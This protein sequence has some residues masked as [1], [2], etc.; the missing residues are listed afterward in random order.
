VKYWQTSV[1]I[2]AALLLVNCEKEPPSLPGDP[3][4]PPK[5]VAFDKVSSRKALEEERT[6]LEL[7]RVE[8]EK[9]KKSNLIQES[10]YRRRAK[11]YEQRITNNKAAFERLKLGN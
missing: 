5:I 10:E 11:V 9:A 7:F 4:A 1:A 2:L 3:P 8:T 6:K